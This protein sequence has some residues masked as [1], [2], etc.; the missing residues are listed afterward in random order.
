MKK[1]GIIGLGKMGYSLLT[2]FMNSGALKEEQVW[3]FDLKKENMD[4]AN[5]HWPKINTG[6]SVEEIVEDADLLFIVVEP[7]DVFNVLMQIKDLLKPETHVI[8]LAACITID[9][10]SNVIPSMIT[11]VIP[12]VLFKHQ[13]GVTLMSHSSRVTS[14]AERFI[15]KLFKRVCTLRVIKEQDFEAVA[16]YTSV[17]PALIAS[18]SEEIVATGLKYSD[19]SREETE[20]LLLLTIKGTIKMLQQE[21]LSF[22]NM[23]DM[24]ATKG[25]ITEAGVKVLD[26]KFPPIME[27]FFNITLKKHE[28]IK[29]ELGKKFE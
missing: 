16:N 1:T 25:G 4:K 17:G 29:A 13:A 8:S 22:A 28:D 23:V 27:E 18:L 3:I 20:E 2:G 24:V 14:Q 12:A 7:K 11:K 19:I 5:S 6:E 26:K 10:I 9:N 21:G 15:E